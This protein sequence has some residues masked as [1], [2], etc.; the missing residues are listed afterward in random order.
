MRRRIMLSSPSQTYD[1]ESQIT[2]IYNP[3]STQ[4]ATQILGSNFTISQINT[5][6]IDGVEQSNVSRTYTFSDTNQ[7]EVTFMLSDDINTFKYMFYQCTTLESVNLKYAKTENITNM[8]CMFYGCSSLISINFGKIDTSN[9][10]TMYYMFGGCTSLESLDLSHFNTENLTSLRYAFWKCSSLISLDLSCLNMSK[11]T[12]MMCM[13]CRCTNI[14]TFDLSGLDT[15]SVTNMS[16]IFS[17]DTKLTKV[18]MTGDV[19]KVTDFTEMFENV[20]TSG[21]LYYNDNYDYSSVI[22]TLPSNWSIET[23]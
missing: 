19:S 20:T 23:I 16:Y 3:T 18:I 4:S 17:N 6:Y 5:V 14:E 2:A 21:T 15:S 7:H 13:L 8:K 12:D 1:Y 10:T 9:V 22:A 11:V